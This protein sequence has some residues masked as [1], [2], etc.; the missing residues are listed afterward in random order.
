MSLL[1]SAWPVVALLLPALVLVSA[2]VFLVKHD[3]RAVAQLLAL[4][5]CFFI[6][7]LLMEFFTF[8]GALMSR[9]GNPHTSPVL[10]T[11][12]RALLDTITDPRSF[13]APLLS[14]PALAV[15]SI[16]VGYGWLLV[17]W[18]LHLRGKTPTAARKKPA[19][20]PRK[21]SKI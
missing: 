9:S 13:T 8:M 6:G 14:L 10:G 19:K 20:A 16:A 15:Y 5:A 21:A 11:G 12:T 1:L 7:A 4:A 18:V 2:I 17:T 3:H